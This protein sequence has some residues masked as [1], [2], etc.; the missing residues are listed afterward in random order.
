M[1]PEL[2]NLSAS[3]TGT[4]TAVFPNADL[5]DSVQV[6]RRYELC[7]FTM[8][9]TITVSTNFAAG[10]FL[11]LNQNRPSIAITNSVS[12]LAKQLGVRLP[13][14]G[15]YP[16]TTKTLAVRFRGDRIEIPSGAVLSLY[17]TCQNPAAGSQIVSNVALQLVPL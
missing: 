17:V 7:G 2:F 10:A 15:T 4:L 3:S 5:F 11:L 1:M 12:V 9:T 16:T 13:G 8:T 14:S 6:P